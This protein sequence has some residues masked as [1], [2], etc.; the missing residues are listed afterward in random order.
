[1]PQNWRRFLN[2][3]PPLGARINWGH[4]LA[5][6]LVGAW[7]FNEGGGLSVTSL[8][9]RNDVLT[10]ASLGSSSDLPTW[11]PMVGGKP[12]SG[13]KITGSSSL[14]LPTLT[15]ATPSAALLPTD[16]VSVFWA[17]SLLSDMNATL[18]SLPPLVAMTANS[19]ITSPFI[20]YGIGRFASGTNVGNKE[21][22]FYSDMGGFNNFGYTGPISAYGAYMTAAFTIQSGIQ[23][24]YVNGYQALAAQGGSG[25]MS[26]G[27][28][29]TL[30]V[31][32]FNSA[33]SNNV[34]QS[35]AYA[36]YI[37]HRIVT[38][39]EIAWLHDEPFALIEWRHPRG[40]FFFGHPAT[41]QVVTPNSVASPS[42]VGSPMIIGP[43]QAVT[44]LSIASPATVGLPFLLYG[45]EVSP[46][47]IASPATVG[48]PALVGD[49]QTVVPL[50]V[51]SPATVGNPTIIGG[52]AQFVTPLS[53]AS[54]ATVG[55]P[56]IV[57]PAQ[58]VILATGVPSPA[59]VGNP[60]V[61]G[62]VQGLQLFI[63]NAPVD[64]LVPG[65]MSW[66]RYGGGG[67]GGGTGAA[68]GGPLT[69]TQTAIGR[70]TCS[71]DLNVPDSSGYVPRATQTVIISENGEKLFGGCI[72][73]VSSDPK[74]GTL[75]AAADFTQ[76][77]FHVDCV[78]KSSICDQRVVIKTYPVGTDVQGMILDIV[79]NF[80]NG[81]GITTQGV[82][83]TDTLDSAMVF[84]T[85]T[86]AAAFDQITALTGAQWW[87]DFNGVLYFTVIQTSPDAPFNLSTTSFNFRNIVSTETTGQGYANKFYAISNL[88]VLP[89]GASGQQTG[90]AISNSVGNDPGSGYTI[91]DTLSIIGGDGDAV[92]QVT[93]VAGVA[94]GVS[95]Y[96]I[97][98]PG[99]GYQ[100][101]INNP[102]PTSAITGTGM[103][104]TIDINGVTTLQNGV[105]GAV[106]TETYTFVL[107][108]GSSSGQQVAAWDAGLAPG[109]V[110]L[111]LPIESV[112][113]VS[114]NGTSVNVYPLSGGFQP[115]NA[116][117]WF[118]GD[119]QARVIFP[120]NFLPAVGD[121]IKIGYIP[122]NQNASVQTGTPLT[123]TCGSGLVEGIIQVP[124][125]DVQSQL[126]AIAAGFLK[127]NGSGIPFLISYETD[128][129]G[130][131]I[132]QQ[133]V[134]DLPLQGLATTTVY[135]TSVVASIESVNRGGRSVSRF[136][137]AFRY[138]IEA[139]TQQNSGNWLAW[140]ERFI[141][142]TNYPLPVPR[143]EQAIL[144]L[145]PG[146]S[147]AGGTVAANTYE[148]KNAGTVFSFSAQAEVPP[149][150]QNLLLQMT[151]NNV[152]L[153]KSPLVIPAGINTT[154]YAVAAQ[155]PAGLTVFKG[156]LFRVVVSYQVLT[157]SPTAAGSVSFYCDWSY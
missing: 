68:T 78:D 124:N 149:V 92:L 139:S 6:N 137:S 63:A 99:T 59:T 13:V 97:T 40:L 79:K 49:P 134:I 128:Q 34:A 85:V 91:G 94:N 107:K 32:N 54:P 43:D 89:A 119:E 24:P 29:P 26:Y 81:E 77:L 152:P 51:L 37:H 145:S 84:N 76:I 28:G 135:L 114:I 56:N 110:L 7:L 151:K 82:D 74:P 71:F 20:A 98:N 87:I 45:Q 72:K 36:V 148:A 14:L 70:A 156:D 126:D 113:T 100:A 42:A 88:T 33:F 132:G 15:L 60:V 86:V 105:A 130:L 27:S 146:G 103:G 140:F 115:G 125:I 47:S 44:P 101:V 21:L 41:S 147:I 133:Q 117:Y 65:G 118:D 131:A 46:L 1:M 69:I 155:I 66:P 62:G 136:G 16:M 8:I 80:L 48:M 122:V 153:L 144:V 2:S 95:G 22:S 90:G 157:A 18:T 109:Y 52:T 30:C 129:P 150:G 83:V 25:S 142:R 127:R 93:A 138:V 5:K 31:G 19:A 50:S 3:K 112:Q 10:F 123:G 75:N 102:Y 38:P 57:G 64:Y 58:T 55:N 12:G 11:Q 96:T 108:P 53:I 106:R 116:Y 141:A 35:M 73:S 61:D 67:G 39:T 143:Y 121:V 23:I 111:E 154:V 9:N 104:F 4:P 17:G 120:E